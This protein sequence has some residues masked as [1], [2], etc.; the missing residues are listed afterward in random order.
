MRAT[1]DAFIQAVED[2]R[3]Q[4]IRREGSAVSVREIL[5]RAG[6]TEADRAGAA[7]HLNRNRVWPKGHRVPPE[8][9]ER[10]SKVLPVS[11]EELAAAAQAAAGYTVSTTRPDLYA[12]A[13]F[14]E[15]DDTPIEEKE[16]VVAALARLIANQMG[17][18]RV[19]T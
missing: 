11:H 10:L 16:E 5:R 9:V 19:G 14:L 8:L 18:R 1:M 13:R 15:D 12:V 6:Y 17:R 3:S 2:A 7:Y 4:L